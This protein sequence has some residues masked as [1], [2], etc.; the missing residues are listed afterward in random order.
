M[1][2]E[3]ENETLLRRE[4]TDP[5][6]DFWHT[7]RVGLFIFAILIMVLPPIMD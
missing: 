5:C 4:K 7:M 2:V 1:S 3:S 6:S